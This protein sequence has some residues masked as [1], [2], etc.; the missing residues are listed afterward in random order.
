MYWNQGLTP[1]TSKDKLNRHHTLLKSRSLYNAE[2]FFNTNHTVS[3]LGQEEGYTVKYGLSLGDFPR[4]NP[5]KFLVTQASM[6]PMV[7]ETS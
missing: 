6:G 5:L 1:T 4:G 3:V 7:R 2:P